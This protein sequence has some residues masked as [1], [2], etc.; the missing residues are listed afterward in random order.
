MATAT[1][2]AATAEAWGRYL[3]DTQGA[4]DLDYEDVEAWAWARLQ[5]QLEALR[6]TQRQESAA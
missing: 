6:P 2:E 1:I 5:T 4:P 3:A